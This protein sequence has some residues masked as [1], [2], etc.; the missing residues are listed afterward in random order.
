MGSWYYNICII[1]NTYWKNGWKI[2][3]L[4]KSDK[5]RFWVYDGP[6]ARKF[7][8]IDIP[9]SEFEKS[10]EE[11]AKEVRM[12]AVKTKNHPKGFFVE[13]VGAKFG[14]RDRL[15]SILKGSGNVAQ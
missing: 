2:D 3:F 11:L 15:V 5:L 4:N 7:K 14:D 13:Q 1:K 12:F 9:Y 6:L 10:E 8:P